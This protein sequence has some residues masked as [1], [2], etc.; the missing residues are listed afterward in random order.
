M[1]FPTD[2]LVVDVIIDPSVEDKWNRWYDEVHLPE[3]IDCPGFVQS[4]RYR[5][6]ERDGKVHYITLYE[7]RNLEALNSSE[8]ARR[9]GWGPF[10]DKVDAT[11]RA[12]RRI[13][14]LG[15]GSSE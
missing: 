3:I 7:L 1:P 6:V 8:F 11:V 5:S 2:L 13:S 9:R 15:E 12:Y 4:A 10:A 14:A